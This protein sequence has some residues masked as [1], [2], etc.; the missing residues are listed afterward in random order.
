MWNTV[1]CQPLI[2]I[3]KTLEADVVFWCH[4]PMCEWPTETTEG[5]ELSNL[6]FD[7]KIRK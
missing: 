2:S 1:K 5:F 4:I 7:V 3:I 6:N